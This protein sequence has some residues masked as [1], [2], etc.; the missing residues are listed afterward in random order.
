L[1]SLVG[2][3]AFAVDRNAASFDGPENRQNALPESEVFLSG[4]AI[5]TTQ[6]RGL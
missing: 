6:G 1:I 3:P 5:T 4:F 2:S